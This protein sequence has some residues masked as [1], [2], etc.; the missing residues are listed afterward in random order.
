MSI[1]SDVQTYHGFDV[2]SV[3]PVPDCNASGIYLRHRKTGLEVFHLLN[4][5]EEN[6]F[7]FAFRTPP[8]D[9]TGAAHILEHSVLCG[10]ERYPLKDPFIHLVNQSVK[11]FLNALTFPDKTVFPASSMVKKDYFNL[12]SVYGDAVFFPRLDPEIFKQEAHRLEINNEGTY[13]IQ[14]VVYNEM[15]GNYSSFDSIAGDAAFRSLFPD[16]VYSLDSG[17]DPLQIPLITHDQLKA[18]HKKYYR[19]NNCLVF[20][21]GNIPT[22]TQLD[23][24]DEQFLSRLE[25]RQAENGNAEGQTSLQEIL[26][27]E[28][29]HPFT[30]PVYIEEKGP[31]S[32]TR[33]NGASVMVSWLLGDTDDINRYM[34]SM[35]ISEILCGHDGSPLQKALLESGLGQDIAPCTGV[36]YDIRSIVM[37]AGLRGVEQ[38]N[39]KKVEQLIFSVLNDICRKGLSP[40]DIDSAVMSVNFMNRE[41]IRSGGPYSLVLMRRALRSWVYGKEP[42]ATLGV[43]SAFDA[44]RENI[45]TDPSYITGCIK[46]LLVD[47]C[48]RSLVAVTPDPSYSKERNKQEQKLISDA[49]GQTSPEAVKKAAEELH[50]F[51]QKKKGKKEMD[52]L[53]HIHPSELSVQ[54]D[55]I[56]TEITHCSSETGDIPLFL[57]T[58]NTNSII[59]LDV[60][61][62]ADV[63]PSSEYPY[64]PLFSIEAT[65][66]GWKGKNWSETASLTG[67]TCGSL[68]ATL[69]TSSAVPGTAHSTIYSGR[70]WIIFRIKMLSEKTEEALQLLADCLTGTEYT[71]RKRLQNLASEYRNDMDESVIPDGHDFALSRS[72]CR[73]SRSKAVDEIWNGLSQLYTLHSLAES[74]MSELGRHFA[75]ISAALRKG[76]AVLH[77]TADHTGI[78]TVKQLLPAFI[79]QTGLHAPAA[80]FKCCDDDFYVLTAIPGYIAKKTADPQIYT[81]QS[82]V[83]FT[84]INI[85]A[86]AWWS[87]ECAAELVFTHWFSTTFLWEQLR[88]IGG[89][90]GA[91]ASVDA[92]EQQMSFLTY[93]D[94]SPFTSIDV[95]KKCLKKASEITLDDVSVEKAITGTYSH[96][97]QPRSPAGRGSTGFLR[98]LYGISNEARQKKILDILSVTA[99]DIKSASERL[100]R[101]SSTSTAAVICGKNSTTTDSGIQLPV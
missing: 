31:A 75:A 70:D 90:Y 95:F 36:L 16:T 76:G 57:N 85:P 86:S 65:N 23:F 67:I 100:Y 41:I 32:D 29:V 34:E 97:V 26:K 15:K 4:N 91:V 40:D 58:E 73:Y 10:S 72:A 37:T 79:R 98:C 60:A 11:T 22:E 33:N 81:V 101:N 74:D 69:F 77:I 80:P 38:K 82:Q 63:L 84:G 5:D 50:T 28:T 89:A 3:T 61:Y 24:I 45:R 68:N 43:R 99:A 47:N 56:C 71:D 54:P 92:A 59:Y 78:D 21:Y 46:R 14:G 39:I 18:F 88:T 64:L 13:S 51:Q 6:L 52:C 17:G 44:V 1:T 35:I 53:P 48:H 8:D 7:A 27:K 83:G 9:S 96:E 42:S 49:A 19:S 94:P 55:T 93:R 12:M 62:P 66:N 87:R 2:I 25:K 20:L 30:A